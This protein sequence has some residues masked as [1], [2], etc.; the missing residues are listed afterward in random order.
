MIVGW[1]ARTQTVPL[2]WPV[3]GLPWWT[4]HGAGLSVGATL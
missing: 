4:P 3:T 1:Y 2:A